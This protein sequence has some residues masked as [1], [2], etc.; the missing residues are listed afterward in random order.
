[1]F[2]HLSPVGFGLAISCAGPFL[3]SL[4]A[5]AQTIRSENLFPP[6]EVHGSLALDDC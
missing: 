3:V 1:M 6:S 4:E 2:A 5:K